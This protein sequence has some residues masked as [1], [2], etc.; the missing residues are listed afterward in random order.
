[1]E[2]IYLDKRA[3]VNGKDSVI[4]LDN[5]ILLNDF[6]EKIVAGTAG[7][8]NITATSPGYYTFNNTVNPPVTFKSGWTIG[9]QSLNGDIT[10]TYPDNTSS[11]FQVV[12]FVNAANGLTKTGNTIEL[13]GALTK[14][15]VVSSTNYDL[16]FS[17]FGPTTNNL[18]TG[19]SLMGLV[20][21]AVLYTTLDASG[22]NTAV[23]MYPENSQGPGIPANVVI[24]AVKGG[25]VPNF[26]SFTA[27]PFK[28]IVSSGVT[29]TSPTQIIEVTETLTT[30]SGNITLTDYPDSRDD[31]GAVFPV[32]MLY[33]GTGGELL[34]ADFRISVDDIV[35]DLIVDTN[36]IDVTYITG[37]PNQVE[38]DV[39]DN[40][41]IQKIEISKGG[42][43]IGTR[44]GINF[45]QGSNVTL[46]ATDDVIND[47]V[48]LTIASAGGGGGGGL[49]D[50]YYS[51]TDGTN[52]STA[53]TADIFKFRSANNILSALVTDDD[54][55]HGDNLLLTVNQGNIDHNALLNYS[56]NRHIDHTAVS[57]IAGAAMTGGGNIASN[58]TISHSDTSSV[59]DT[60][61]TGATFLQN[62]TFDTYGHVQ[63]VSSATIT[64]LAI[65]AAASSV[66]I[67]G[68]NGLT[69]GGDLTAN[70][71]IEHADT[72]SQA[73]LT[74]TGAEVPDQMQFDTYGH[75]TSATKRNLTPSDIGIPNGAAAGQ[76]L[77]WTGAVWDKAGNYTN[78]QQYDPGIHIGNVVT[79][80]HLPVSALP[81]NVYIN[82][83]LKEEGPSADYTRVGSNFT[84]TYSFLTIDKITITYYA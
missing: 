68:I 46:T 50:A 41:S 31:S 66:T 80:P 44:K 15:T 82:G 54:I 37:T 65:G 79:I 56:V 57:I 32:N 49:T 34:S 83:I 70:R 51:F 30:L 69:G 21:G 8:A 43:L 53:T 18:N 45:I 14:P 10:L 52:T 48:N 78:I 76:I 67:T 47:R 58:V 12:N 20:G 75:V 1:M 2:K 23:S 24:N 59:G 84:F 77:Y 39:I 22:T 28:A 72:S 16:V 26:S 29:T 81:I 71:T 9:A 38:L 64:P 35:G 73:N 63:T 4:Y 60:V 36:T 11:T 61:N 27:T 55:T 33:T 6:V 3:T 19:L 74:F 62:A 25:I 42:T 17:R 13:G 5:Y 7:T 40:S